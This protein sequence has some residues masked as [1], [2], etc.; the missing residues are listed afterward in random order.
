MPDRIARVQQ[1][2]KAVGLHGLFLSAPSSLRYLFGFTGTNGIGLI[3]SDL[4]YFATDWRY[5]DQAQEEVRG[6]EILVAQRDLI[7]AIKDRNPLAENA[8]AGIE[9][10]HLTYSVLAQIRKHF[11]KLELKLTEH[12]LGKIAAEKS[13]EEIALLKRAAQ[14]TVRVWQNVL[15][16]LRP[17]A[18]EADVT[19]ELNYIARKCGSQIEPFEPIVAGGPR[20]ALPH[21]RSSSRALQHGDMVVID[22]GC[23]VEGY[24]ADFT[25]TIAVGE[26]DKKLRDAY[27]V[28]KEAGELAYEAARAPMKAIDLDA[29]ARKHFEAHG[30][31]TYFNHS[32]GHG[33]GLDVH[34][35]PRIGPESKDT[36][37]V[38]AV[39]AIEP[40]V[41]FPGLGGIRIED[42]VLVTATACE[43]L[44]PAPRELICVE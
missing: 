27:R 2:L 26:P 42:D 7:G 21:A 30:L 6:T 18:T 23:V 44:T 25:R 39:L 40:G 16:H 9:E 28:V 20:S 37:P 22:F 31:A 15:P 4:S 17:G 38:N 36:I 14:L 32:L 12:L 34:S 10:H 35:L 11:P 41:Y 43:I 5:R 13:P 29:V 8:N 33:L 1:R 3:T 24:A 19:A